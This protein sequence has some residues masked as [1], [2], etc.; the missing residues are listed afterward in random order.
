MNID[1]S[2]NKNWLC[3]KCQKPMMLEK[4][5]VKYLG[6]TFEVDL[7]KCPDCKMVLIDEELARGKMLDVEQNLEDK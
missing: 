3:G 4:T 6:G 1:Q 5:T 7:L 2:K